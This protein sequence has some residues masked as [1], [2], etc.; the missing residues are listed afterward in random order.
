MTAVEIPLTADA[1]V[2]TITLNGVAYQLTLMWRS[3]AGWV[4]DIADATGNALVG[5]IALVTGVDLLGQFAYLG[6][7]GSLAVLTAGDI[8]Q[9]PDFDGL[10]TESRLYFVTT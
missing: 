1:Q 8:Q 6:I 7:G 9:P 2:F 3:G 10:G 5:G 4:L